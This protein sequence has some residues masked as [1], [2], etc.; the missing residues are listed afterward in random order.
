MSSTPTPP[1]E[2][3]PNPETGRDYTIRMDLPEF[4][5]VCP[6]TGQPDFAHLKLEY[7][8]AALCVE[9]KSLKRYLW[10]FRDEGA[11]HEAITNRIAS[12]LVTVLTPRFL[13]LHANFNVRGGI[14]TEVVAEHRADGWIAPPPVALP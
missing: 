5:C 8:P 11:F 7:V 3:F 2:T 12:D 4:T 14:Y 6:L 9:L 13:R 10:S 1:L